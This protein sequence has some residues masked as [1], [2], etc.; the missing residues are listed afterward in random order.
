M[1]IIYEMHSERKYLHRS[2]QILLQQNM[3]V[4]YKYCLLPKKEV[5]QHNI[6]NVLPPNPWNTICFNT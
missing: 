2:V 3:A 5:I 6:N 4:F 1:Y